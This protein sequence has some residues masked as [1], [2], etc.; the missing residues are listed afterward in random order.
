MGGLELREP[1]SLEPKPFS[2]KASPRIRVM[3]VAQAPKTCQRYF[4]KPDHACDDIASHDHGR[5]NGV[6]RL[7]VLAKQAEPE[8]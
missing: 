4:V 8:E 6:G 5:Y 3:L 2:E 1:D 7:S